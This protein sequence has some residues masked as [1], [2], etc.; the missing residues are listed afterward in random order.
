MFVVPVTEVPPPITDVY[1]FLTMS[2]ELTIACINAQ[3]G[4]FKAFWY[5]NGQLR[6]KDEVNNLLTIMDAAS[7]GQSAKF[8]TQGKALVDIIELARPGSLGLQ[9][10]MPPYD[11]TI[12][13]NTFALRVV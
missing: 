13:P 11:Y 12:D 2:N 7:P 8:F 3:K 5:K 9:D 10:W 1:S 6:S 4:I